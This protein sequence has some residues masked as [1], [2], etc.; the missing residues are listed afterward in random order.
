MS[1]QPVLA[2]N[3]VHK[4]YGTGTTAKPVLRG[5]S[6][7]VEPNEVVALL[8]ANGAGKTTLVNIA[9][10]LL[11]PDS[12]TITVC[13]HD[14][15]QNPERVRETISL[16]G[17][18]AAVDGELTGRENLIFFSRLH[19]MRMPQ[20][21]AR[22][23]ALLD[24]FR[25]TNAAN[26]RVASYSGGMRRR[27]DIASSLV[28][29]PQLLFL[30]EPTTGLDPRSRRE[31]WDMV[32]ALAAR[33]VAIL[34]T[35]QYLD[36][37]ERLADKVVMIRGGVN[38]MEGPPVELRQQFGESVGSVTCASND[39]AA[40]AAQLL[41]QALGI[42]AE[43]VTRTNQTVSF[44]VNG[45]PTDLAR[46]LTALADANVPVVSA[47]VAPPSLDDVFLGSAFE[48]ASDAQR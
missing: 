7:T 6:F 34:L 42:D 10:T 17:Q 13:G 14:V 18:F 43:H 36:E 25:L 32:D 46:A 39:A 21:R 20:A 19:G 23:E 28:V 11:L 45:G 31:L 1:S 29:E 38:I 30:D 27:L 47:E 15:V 9:S 4:A 16:T 24:E 44:P 48:E 8:G 12:G 33:G 5:L 41:P 22:A 2:V 40:R 26:Q 37:A 3:N 35:T